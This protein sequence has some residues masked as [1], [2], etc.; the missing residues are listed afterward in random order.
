MLLYEDKKNSV[1]AILRTGLSCLPHLH[2]HI[3]VGFLVEGST[4]MTVDEEVFDLKAEDAFLIFP[5][6]IH[7]FEDNGSISCYLLICSAD[8]T[9]PFTEVFKKNLPVSP[10]VTPKDAD[11]LRQVFAV[12][13]KRGRELE[14]HPDETFASEKVRAFAPAIISE[15][16]PSLSLL[17]SSSAD[18][19]ATQ[20]ILLYCDTHYRDELNLD[21]LSEELGYSKYYIS[22]V[23]SDNVKIGFSRYLRSLRVTAAK[24]MIRHTDMSM[25]D[26]AI[27]S[28]FSSIRTFN[29]QF[30]EETGMTPTEYAKKRRKN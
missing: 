22:H 9:S 7:S 8:D 14:L 26:V 11:S 4:R 21:L 15:L 17:P 2:S 30:F 27:E 19:D 12:A 29:R 1:S 23:F 24:R 28:G 6:R 10:V 3:E 5:N 25:T 20:R 16:V 18:P 13:S